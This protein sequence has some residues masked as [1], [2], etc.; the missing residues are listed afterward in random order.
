[1]AGLDCPGQVTDALANAWQRRPTAVA[2]AEAAWSPTPEPL[3][4]LVGSPTGLSVS[5]QAAFCVGVHG[6]KSSWRTA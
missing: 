6:P 3:C 4:W 2:V 1:M 5:A